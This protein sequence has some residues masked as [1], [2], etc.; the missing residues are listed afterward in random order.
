MRMYS[1]QTKLAISST[2]IMLAA[3]AAAMANVRGMPKPRHIQERD[4]NGYRIVG[5]LDRLARKHRRASQ[6]K[7]GKRARGGSR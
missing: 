4:G 1:G 5:E 2:P 7:P 6:G 3:T